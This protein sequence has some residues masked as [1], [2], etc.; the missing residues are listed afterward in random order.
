MRGRGWKVEG[1]RW[2]KRKVEGE[3]KGRRRKKTEEV[4]RR[5]GEIVR[6]KEGERDGEERR[7]RKRVGE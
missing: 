1:G 4:G 7:V 3:G 6:W 5:G 2:W